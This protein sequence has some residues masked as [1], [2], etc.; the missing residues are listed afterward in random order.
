VRDWEE[1]G[2]EPAFGHEG[3]WLLDVVEQ[4]GAQEVA[5]YALQSGAGRRL[6]VATDLGL[7]DAAV[8]E[9][10]RRVPTAIDLVPWPEVREVHLS[11]RIE[12]DGSLR[13]V[14]TYSLAV[15]HPTVEVAGA[16][17]PQ[18]LLEFARTLL[19]RAHRPPTTPVPEPE[20]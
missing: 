16:P 18:A 8:D 13:H 2:I 9:D 15:G 20:D 19:L 10:P 7:V 4:V 14:P 5:V 3:H 12:V 17:A 6:L 1:Q 11:C